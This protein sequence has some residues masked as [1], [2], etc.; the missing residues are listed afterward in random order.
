MKILNIKENKDGSAYLEI[1]LNKINEE[2]LREI[3]KLKKKKYNNEFI[4]KILLETIKNYLRKENE[5]E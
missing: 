1:E 5:S 4:N 2:Q 3:A